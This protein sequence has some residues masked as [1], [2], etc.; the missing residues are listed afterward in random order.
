MPN[1]RSINGA[2]IHKFDD[3]FNYVEMQFVKVK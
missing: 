3:I 2:T 1:I